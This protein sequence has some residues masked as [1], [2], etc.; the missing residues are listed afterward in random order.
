MGWHWTGQ[1]QRVH[2]ADWHHPEGPDSSIEVRA[3]NPVVQVSWTD[4][5]AYCAWRNKRLPS[6]AEWECAARG[7]G[8]RVYAWGDAPPRE[9]GQFRASYGSDACCRA[10]AGDGYLTTAPVA[11]FP[12]GRSP[13]GVED[14]TG[15]VWEWGRGQLRS[16]VLRAFSRARSGK[17]RSRQGFQGHP[18]RWLGEQSGGATDHVATRQPAPVRSV[19]GGVSVC[20]VVGRV[21]G[22][23]IGKKSRSD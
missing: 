22:G 14:L 15:N 9:A 4:A 8:A 6:E 13:F 10:E 7:V 2:G 5:R 17:P 20:P 23:G 11:S 18:R 12:A 1:W 16:H 19:D 21:T 3:S